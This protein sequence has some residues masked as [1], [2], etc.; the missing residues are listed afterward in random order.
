MS[1]IY[2]LENNE[3]LLHYNKLMPKAN[4]I[5]WYEFVILSAWSAYYLQNFQQV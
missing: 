3:Y 2:P 5:Y 4:E 1:Q